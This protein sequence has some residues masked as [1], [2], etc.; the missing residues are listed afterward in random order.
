VLAKWI[1]CRVAAAS[2]PAFSEAQLAWAATADCTGFLGQC[3]G[4]HED[5]AHV[6]ALWKDRRSMEDFARHE[7]EALANSGQQRGFYSAV[8]V[9]VLSRLVEMPGE[10]ASLPQAVP[11]GSFAR[12]SDCTV[13]AS[14]RSHFVEAHL[15]IW[16]PGL[17]RVA[18]LLY[19]TLWAFDDRPNRFLVASLWDDEASHAG[20]VGKTMPALR[21][22]AGMHEDIAH[23]ESRGFGLVRSW[24]V[25]PG[26]PA[27]AGSPVP[28]TAR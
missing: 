21:T 27:W 6:L 17:S 4:F 15:R 7:H 25:S 16:R 8:E 22:Q 28:A 3:G 20:Y 23:I 13:H 26:A 11:A 12:I 2:R 18:G 5:F 10:R 14:R 1:V 19:G 9:H 24:T